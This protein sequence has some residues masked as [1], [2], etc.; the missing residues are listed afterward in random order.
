MINPHTPSNDAILPPT[1]NTLT[2]IPLLTNPTE[3]DG[4]LTLLLRNNPIIVYSVHVDIP[5]LDEVRA[6]LEATTL[7]KNTE[8]AAEYVEIESRDAEEKKEGEEDK[9]GSDRTEPA[10]QEAEAVFVRVPYDK[11]PQLEVIEVRDPHSN[12]ARLQESGAGLPYLTC[13]NNSTHLYVDESSPPPTPIIQGE[14]LDS[15]TNSALAELLATAIV[16]ELMLP[17]GHRC[18]PPPPTN[19]KE[20]YHCMTHDILVSEDG[21]FAPQLP[22]GPG[23]TME[24]YFQGNNCFEPHIISML[25]ERTLHPF[26]TLN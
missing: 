8:D 17:P 24:A 10:D 26:T 3:H 20:D 25:R 21:I 13:F 15:K 16:E 22:K 4:T 9:G 7:S 19:L 23:H 12:I 5:M 11:D 18:L 2:Q 1:D 14:P 6:H